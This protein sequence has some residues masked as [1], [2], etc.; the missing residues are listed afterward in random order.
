MKN[1][2]RHGFLNIVHLA[3]IILSLFTQSTF[4]LNLRIVDT[5]DGLSSMFV[6]SLYQDEM[7]HIW[8]G[9]YN[10]VSILE[11][12]N[13]NVMPARGRAFYLLKGNVIEGIQGGRKGHLWFHSN[14][15]LVHW[16]AN[17]R[18]IQKFSEIYGNYRFA[19]SPNDE[20]IA[21]SQ[22]R[23][24]QYYNGRNN[25]FQPFS[26]SNLKYG[27]IQAMAIDDN[28]RWFVM[29]RNNLYE[30]EIIQANDGTC[31]FRHIRQH[32]CEDHVR[33]ARIDGEDIFFIDEKDML[34]HGTLHD[35]KPRKL[36]PVGQFI[37]KRG[38]IK[39]VVHYGND[40]VIGF[41]IDGVLRMHP[42]QEGTNTEWE[43]TELAVNSGV[44]DIKY[45]KRQKILWVA[46]D[47]EG[48]KYFAD[49][50]YD[51]RTESF[52]QL[53][54]TVSTPGRA[55]QK[56]RNGDLW[57]ATKGDGLLCYVNYNPE[58]GATSQVRNYTTEN[59]PLLH[60]SVYCMKEGKNGI[61][62][63]GSDG[64]GI[65]YYI[66]SQRK[67]GVLDVGGN[68]VD[69]IHGL[70]EIDN[71][72]WAAAWGHGV[73][74]IQLQWEGDVP[75]ASSIKQ[76]LYEPG[77]WELAQFMA[78]EADGGYI[79]AT[80]R[81][82]G[83]TRID[84]K[85]LKSKTIHF[86][87]PRLNVINDVVSLNTQKPEGILFATSAGLLMQPRD[88]TRPFVNLNEGLGIAS[89]PMRSI[90]YTKN[91]HIWFCTPHTLV[92]GNTETANSNQYRIGDG[93]YVNEFVEGA[94]F[95]DREEDIKYFGGTGG[96]VVVSPLREKPKE[97]TPEI[98]FHEIVFSTGDMQILPIVGTKP[99]EIAYNN[100]YFS[101][102][103]DAIDYLNANNYS[104]EYRLGTNDWIGNGHNR[105]ISFVNQSPGNYDLQVRYRKGNYISPAFELKISVLPPWWQSWF[106]MLVYVLA[107]LALVAYLIYRYARKQRR[108]QQYAMQRMNEQHREEV[109]ESK[110]RFFTNITHEFSTPLT[111]IS[112]PCQ[113]ILDTP[114]AS[115]AIKDYATLIQNSS[116]RLNDLIQQLIEFRRIDTGNRVMRI[117][118]TAVT[119]RLI[120]TAISFNL[121]AE[122][123]HIKYKVNAQPNLTWPTDSNAFT[124]ICINLISNAFKYVEA[125]GDITVR[126]HTTDDDQL[127]LIVSNSG[128]G[129][130]QEQIDQMFNRYAIL[131]VLEDTTQSRGFARNGLGLAITQGLIKGLEGTIQVK[132]EE[133]LTTFTVTLPRQQVSHETLQTGG[134]VPQHHIEET[135]M[136]E[137]SNPSSIDKSRSTI[138]V[139]DDNREMTWLLNE[140]LQ[141]DYNVV[142]HTDPET[143]MGDFRKSRI[144]LV[145]SDIV[146][147]PFDG[148]ELCRRIKENKLTN[149]IP[150]ILLS[151]RQNKDTQVAT[152]N[153]GAEA[154][155]SKPF[156]VNYLRSV[157]KNLLKRNQALEDYYNSSLSAFDIVDGKHL[158]REDKEF[159][160]KMAKVIEAN[161]TNPGLTTQ[162]L[163]KE[164]GI[165]LRNIYRR[166]ATFTDL[167]PKDL[168][169]EARL[170]RARILLTKTSMNAE[171][172]CYQAGFGNRGTFYRLFAAKYGCSPG[173]YHEEQIKKAKDKLKK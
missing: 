30:T 15:C 21:V 43:E 142:T 38:K 11:G 57:V 140:I 61:I 126:L 114:G 159:M 29:S 86:E 113:R 76:L 108:R 79:W 117:T 94:T 7:G 36:F 69:N 74:R 75:K 58:T 156:D 67:M 35:F 52:Q 70:T 87:E 157:V 107:I 91:R 73:F 13:S 2:A 42:K 109:Y 37:Q 88:L 8:A 85:T 63:M 81:E 60:N 143:A 10:G 16:D 131:K 95:Y 139:V 53:P 49:E 152:A 82:N 112:G 103:Y 148:I 18:E 59:S 106:M 124:T 66:P 72:L 153:V 146:M 77:H 20:V 151:S 17:R 93:I 47:G 155:V 127:Q 129:I 32:E 149:H 23:G 34:Y 40:I 135:V 83:V 56:D 14:F 45:D 164:M 26:I 46:T 154:F 123:N 172:V 80:G 170:E 99:I 118:E 54:Y 3:T 96:F 116:I 166:M 136:D 89:Q 4:A 144:D 22:E 110:L 68:D 6:M 161:I 31:T 41:G 98:V 145:I 163:A 173:Q 1:M 84:R 5:H 90:I 105:S 64:K 78:V 138:L 55:L 141:K 24:L 133:N 39:S 121:E 132:G 125:N 119:K 92:L 147:E 122:K 65:N 104:F 51:I 48:I 128:P 171:E 19:V 120:D 169:R 27:D 25:S 100:N 44:F 71:E 97:Y 102:R 115:Q 33:W 150:V 162:L 50:P 62:W 158:H 28:H 12:N 134:Y 160:D 101:I 165:G 168:I 130:S 111:L 9:T 137:E 167:T